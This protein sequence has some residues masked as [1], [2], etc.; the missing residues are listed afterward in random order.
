MRLTK[1][2]LLA[3]RDSLRNELNLVEKL[4][5]EKFGWKAS[6]D[7]S[8]GE[9]N[10]SMM[11]AP[12]ETV[13]EPIQQYNIAGSTINS[14]KSKKNKTIIEVITDWSKNLEE[15]SEITVSD[16]KDHVEQVM[17]DEII[18][19]SSV[20]SAFA[21]IKGNYFETIYPGSGRKPGKYRRLENE[22]V[23]LL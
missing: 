9:N 5:A 14:N 18:H 6:D 21:K 17:K 15:G 10:E 20:S 13:R 2:N 12:W 4:L 22:L 16:V 7:K 11:P 1:E 19:P 3:E 23:E 8:T